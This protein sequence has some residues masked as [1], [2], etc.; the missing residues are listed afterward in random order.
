LSSSLPR[1][2]I[3]ATFS[4]ET[5]GLVERVQEGGD[6][7]TVHIR[8]TER[9]STIIDAAMTDHLANY[10]QLLSGVDRDV[11]ERAAADLREISEALGDTSIS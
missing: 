4:K 9:G 3:S 7:R 6:R 1:C 2:A 8:L 5:K 10:A 11:V